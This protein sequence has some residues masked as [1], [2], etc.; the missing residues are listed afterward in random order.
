MALTEMAAA[1]QTAADLAPARSAVR[2]LYVQYTNP[3]GYPP[4][5]QGARLLAEQGATVVFVGTAALGDRLRLAPHP[6]IRA[7]LLPPA[8]PGW[9]QKLHYVRFTWRAL[10]RALS[11]RPHW[12]YASDPLSAPAAL[13][14]AALTRAGVVYHE[15]DSPGVETA[16]EASGPMRLVMAARG[17]LVRRAE[18][19]VLPS[20][21]RAVGF[22]ETTGRSDV[23]TVWNTPLRRDATPRPRSAATGRLRVLYQGSIVA[24]RLPIAVIEAISRLPVPVSLRIVGYDPAGGVHVTRLRAAAAR[25]GIADRVELLDA[26]PRSELLQ[27][28]DD[29]EVGLA[30]LPRTSASL[31]E[32][33]MV[34]ASNKPFEYLACGLPLLVTDRPD[35]R[36][37]FVTPGYGIA[38]DPESPDSVASAL[39][40][41]LDHPD[42]RVHMGERGR[43]RVLDAWNYDAA[44]A[45]VLTRLL[46]GPRRRG[47]A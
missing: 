16:E 39:Q 30:L 36:D 38:C 31:N 46:A 32:Q 47:L 43:R 34:G 9:S 28:S 1:G 41:Y 21:P 14:T 2:V 45:P 20:G 42:E 10:V 18:F 26:R 12:I 5:E 6:H 19:C 35:W 29:C 13:V 44:F 25:L 22:V 15:H 4:L 17:R 40:W 27:Q 3:A 23:I 7:E 8:E 24:S 33:T 11:F 37:A